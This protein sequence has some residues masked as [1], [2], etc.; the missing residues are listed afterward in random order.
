VPFRRVALFLA[1]G[2]VGLSCG[3]CSG[4]PVVKDS[5]VLEEFS[6]GCRHRIRGVIGITRPETSRLN[7]SAI[8][9]L[10]FG[11]PSE[12]QAYGITGE[13]PH[14]LWKCRYFGVKDGSVLLRCEHHE[15]HFSVVKRA[16]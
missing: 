12:P 5:R 7:C 9:E 4:A 1:V 6:G 13:A 2:A 8:Q 15:R 3:A 14:L 16:S 10:T 11:L